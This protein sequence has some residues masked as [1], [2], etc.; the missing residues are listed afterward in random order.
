[1]KI[2]IVSTDKPI[3][4]VLNTLDLSQGLDFKNYYAGAGVNKLGGNKGHINTNGVGSGG[5]ATHDSLHF[6]GIKDRY[7]EKSRD[8]KHGRR[9]TPQKGYEDNI[10]ATSGGT[11]LTAGQIKEAQRNRSTK[12]CTEQKGTI[13]CN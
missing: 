6:A 13:T 7:D 3:N 11:K 9:A 1:V 5:D 10:M 4:G 2:K 12:K 8:P